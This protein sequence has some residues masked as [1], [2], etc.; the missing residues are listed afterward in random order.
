[1]LSFQIGH[2]FPKLKVIWGDGGYD[3]QPLQLWVQRWFN[4]GGET[5]KCNQDTKGFE[6]LP[7]RTISFGTLALTMQVCFVYWFSWL[8]KSDPIW[9]QEGSAVYLLW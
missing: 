4:W 1:M 2:L 5:I 9:H 3:G 8:H 7:K 6:V